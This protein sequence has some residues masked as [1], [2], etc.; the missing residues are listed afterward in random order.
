MG[1]KKKID[2]TPLRRKSQQGK[3]RPVATSS[4]KRKVKCQV[5]GCDRYCRT[6]NIKRHYQN[7]VVFKS[8]GTPIEKTHPKFRELSKSKQDHT[9][10]FHL[11][12]YT[13]NHLPQI[14]E[15]PVCTNPFQLAKQRFEKSLQT[16]D[17]SDNSENSSDSEM[18]VVSDD[19]DSNTDEMSIN[20][21]PKLQASKENI[22]DR[23]DQF[24]G[25]NSPSINCVTHNF[26]LNKD[27]PISESGCSK[28]VDAII[29]KIQEKC[30]GIRI[31]VDAF[32]EI[33]AK[34][35]VT[36]LNPPEDIEAEDEI[37]GD[38]EKSNWIYGDENNTCK[39]CLLFSTH[40]EV[41]VN[42]KSLRKG[43]FGVVNT[44]NQSEKY[45]SRNMKLHE[46][47]QLHSWCCQ[48]AAEAEQAC[49]VLKEK[50]EL[51]CTVQ[52][53]NALFT[54]KNCGSSKD[55]VKENDKDMIHYTITK[56]GLQP[57]TKNDGRQEFFDIRDKAFNLLTDDI[58]K[59]F[60][61]VKSFSVTLDKVTTGHQAY[62]VIM[63]YYFWDGAINILL[64]RVQPMTSDDYDGLGTAIMVKETLQDT[65]GMS[66]AALAA[67]CH[68]F[69]YDG[70]YATEEERLT[71]S[72][73][74]LIDYF[75][76]ELG[77]KE[78][79]IT[80]NWDMAHMLQLA[81]GDVIKS[82]KDLFLDNLIN[83]IFRLMSD[84]NS[85][86]ASLI[87][88]EYARELHYCVLTNKSNQTTRFVRA[89]LR[90]IQSL[91]R[92]L[93]CLYNVH[94]KISEDAV[95]SND[96]TT[97]KESLN[98]QSQISD[99]KFIASVVGIAQILEEYAL[100]SL[101]SQ[102]L[103]FFPTSVLNSSEIHMTTIKQLG[104]KWCWNT[105]NLKLSS[106]GSPQSIIQNLLM[107]S[108]AP[109]VSK[110]AV[111]RAQ[112]KNNIYAKF[113]NTVKST[114]AKE[115]DENKLETTDEDDQQPEILSWE[116]SIPANE[117]GAGSF[118]VINFSKGDLTAIEKK[119]SVVA[120]SIHE[121][122][123]LR[124]NES[125]LILAAKEAF[126]IKSDSRTE[127]EMRNS[128]TKVLQNIS[129]PSRDKFDLNECLPGYKLFV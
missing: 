93:A 84:F 74:K 68:H 96:N 109:Y 124:L 97:A 54:L 78:G 24:N 32:A 81:Y 50:N 92:N 73:L 86:K 88:Q 122:Y 2:K 25:E 53:T 72:G 66:K 80:G 17:S 7:T 123:S 100:L 71:G 76:V 38:I 125:K 110:K 106:I 59:S 103:K 43:L 34:K 62:T 112:V 70:V 120:K 95:L 28:L 35:V 41:P 27:N 1:R 44:L 60:K 116:P 83:K 98:M 94:G 26:S 107:G 105:E 128:L 91:L 42:L 55:F 117:Y 89:L 114:V 37:M 11:N 63:T 21:K 23:T 90:G 18:E 16:V 127:D 52:V 69:A 77:L 4:C 10:F 29:E 36:T 111:I 39:K 57:P 6:D 82:K 115:D 61:K 99:G 48:F 129:G 79:D 126:T 14:E 85:G 8:D 20:E 51:A 64:N 118:P 121:R 119:L 12:G 75:A 67:K 58:R 49:K 101:D 15:E 40:N 3:G 108:Y 47:N 19:P 104:D 9:V 113:W 87:F 65:L 5:I 46:K 13:L 45:V 56:E 30:P 33:V 31:D 22:C 102:N